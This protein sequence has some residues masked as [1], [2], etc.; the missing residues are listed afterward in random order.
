MAHTEII[1]SGFEN[2]L[3]AGIVIT[4][5]GAQ[6]ANLKQLV[7]YMTG[8]DT[9]I[10]YPNEHLGKSKIEAVKS[11]MY[12]TAVGLVLS[13]FRSLDDR[14]DRYKEAKEN[15]KATRVKK[16]LASKNFFNDILNKTKSLLID[17]L[18][19]VAEL[20]QLQLARRRRGAVRA[21]RIH[22]RTL[23]AERQ[24]FAGAIQL[25]LVDEHPAH[26][27]ADPAADEALARFLV[28]PRAFVVVRC[29]ELHAELVALEKA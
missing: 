10:G 24:D 29:G 22:H 20:A 14:A 11:P 8:M 16:P 26:H 17:D 6:L 18:D 3:A 5:G 2:R 12:A 15:V 13:G 4:G 23:G 1:S 28:R 27:R 25:A 7:E 19:D 9:R 21:G